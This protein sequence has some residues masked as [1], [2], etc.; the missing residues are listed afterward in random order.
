MATTHQITGAAILHTY[1]DSICYIC[2]FIQVIYQLI[3]H[4]YFLKHIT[5]SVVSIKRTG[6]LNY[7]EVFYHPELFFHVL[8][9][10]F[11]PP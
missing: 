7:F 11:L 8:N 5:Y 1:D 10:I 2:H 4:T 9:E 6:S 3:V